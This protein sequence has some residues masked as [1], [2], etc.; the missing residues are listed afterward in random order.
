MSCRTFTAVLFTAL[1]L[2][3]CSGGGGLS[4]ASILGKDAA[5]APV[6]GAPAP[7]SDPNTRAYQAGA[8]AARA[9][10][11][12]Y[13]FD[14]GQLKAAY[15]NYETSRG[16][17]DLTSV[18]KMHNVAYAGVMKAASE[19]PN[20]C[21]DARTRVIKADLTRLLAGDFEAPQKVAQKDDGGLFSGWLDGGS[22]DTG[23][24]FGSNDWWEK[25]NEKAGN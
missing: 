3:G 7:V 24:K 6:P 12:G 17:A 21:S 15:L 22:G 14:A 4:T 25:Q 19:D 11:C 2:S 20:F 9:S 23:P 1:A 16:T 10:K 13:N 5:P 8:V 18:E